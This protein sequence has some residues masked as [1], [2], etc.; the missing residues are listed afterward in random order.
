MGVPLPNTFKQF[1][2]PLYSSI[3]R[4]FCRPHHVLFPAEIPNGKLVIQ[5]KPSND[6]HPCMPLS[7]SVVRSSHDTRDK[8]L[9]NFDPTAYFLR[10]LK[11]AYR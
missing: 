7:K 8:L 10:D 9:V 6:F 5:G 2:T 4:S 11:C 1:M 3:K